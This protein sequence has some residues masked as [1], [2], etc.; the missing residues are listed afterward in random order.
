[1]VTQR[2]PTDDALA[3]I[4]SI[5]EHP[6]APAFHRG[7]GEAVDEQMPLAPDQVEADGYSK[8]GPGSLPALRFTWT[9]R[10]AGPGEYFVDE[11]MGVH[12]NPFVAGPMTAEAAVRFVDEREREARA[13]FEQI[14]SEIMDRVASL[15]RE[16]D[17]E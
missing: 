7:P 14:K 13:R 8:V 12:E 17:E 3:T 15:L 6:D 11:S 9:V 5:L 4:V 1:M 16:G 2:D 10:R